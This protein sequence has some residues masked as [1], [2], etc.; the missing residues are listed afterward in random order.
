MKTGTSSRQN[1][2]LQSQSKQAKGTNDLQ[3]ENCERKAEAM[4]GKRKKLCDEPS[5]E[6]G[7]GQGPKNN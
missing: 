6:R 5:R 7:A 3:N 2:E 1:E 4:E